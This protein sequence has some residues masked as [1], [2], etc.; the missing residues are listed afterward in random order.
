MIKLAIRPCVMLTANVDRLVN[1]ARVEVVH[2]V[3]NADIG[4]GV[5]GARSCSAGRQPLGPQPRAPMSPGPP[6]EYCRTFMWAATGPRA[7][8]GVSARSLCGTQIAR[9]HQAYHIC[10]SPTAEHHSS[11]LG[12]KAGCS[13]NPNPLIVGWFQGALQLQLGLASS[14]LQPLH[15]CSWPASGRYAGILMA[16][17]SA[18]YA[19]GPAASRCRVGIYHQGVWPESDAQ[20]ILPCHGGLN[21]P[22]TH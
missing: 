1:G 17:S 22:L 3:T 10:P 13:H 6:Y 8:T 21:A 12:Y 14:Q 16:F 20:A 18:E 15:C 5:V 7:H 2:I 11:G 4:A 19:V 9:H